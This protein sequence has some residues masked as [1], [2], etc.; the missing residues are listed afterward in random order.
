MAESRSN[1]GRDPPVSQSV[2]VCPAPG[3]EVAPNR[4]EVLRKCV[5]TCDSKVRCG[6]ANSNKEIPV[7]QLWHA[8]G[9]SIDTDVEYRL[10]L[11]SFHVPDVEY[12]NLGH[13]SDSPTVLQPSDGDVVSGEMRTELRLWVANS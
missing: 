7:K 4:L 11:K 5:F 13:I 10:E 2:L 3:F 6:T 12:P 9:K 8:I 1:G